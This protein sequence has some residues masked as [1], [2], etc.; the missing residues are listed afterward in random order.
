ASFS[1]DWSS[2]VC[3]SDLHQPQ[4][5]EYSPLQCGDRHPCRIAEQQP[6]RQYHH[7]CTYEEQPESRPL[8]ADSRVAA[9]YQVCITDLAGGECQDRQSVVQAK[10]ENRQT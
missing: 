6:G 9:A 7:Q 5:A 4:P 2:D 8:L 3:S 1:R 10:T